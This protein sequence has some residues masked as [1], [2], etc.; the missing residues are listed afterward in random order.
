M[1]KIFRAVYGVEPCKLFLWWKSTFSH[2]E[3]KESNLK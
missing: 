3:G 2:A 1:A